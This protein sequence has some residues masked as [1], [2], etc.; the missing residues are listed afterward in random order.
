MAKSSGKAGLVMWPTQALMWKRALN[1]LARGE[2]ARGRQE[3]EEADGGGKTDQAERSERRI[4]QEK[5]SASMPVT[6]RPA[7]PPKALP[8]I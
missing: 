2:V 7:M 1:A 3:Q 4:R 8:A 5:N 6:T